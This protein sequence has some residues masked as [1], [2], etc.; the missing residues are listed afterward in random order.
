MKSR[1]YQRNVIEGEKKMAAFTSDYIKSYRRHMAM[2]I[3]MLL[4]TCLLCVLAWV[5][6]HRIGIVLSAV[7]IASFYVLF[8]HFRQLLWER[9]V[10]QIINKNRNNY[11]EWM[12]LQERKIAGEDWEKAC[13]VFSQYRGIFRERHEELCALLRE[14]LKQKPANPLMVC[15][16]AGLVFL[17]EDSCD[18]AMLFNAKHQHGAAGNMIPDIWIQVLNP[19]LPEDGLPTHAECAAEFLV[20]W[21]KK[22]GT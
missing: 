7:M 13:G 15:V 21:E 2:F 10:I 19:D 18:Y 8:Q 1:L 5:L 16:L 14:A 22:A 11:S 12:S 4:L 20:Y 6:P 3:G 17:S 9:E